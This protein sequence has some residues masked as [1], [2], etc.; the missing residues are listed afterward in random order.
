MRPTIEFALDAAQR[1]HPN[2]SFV[3]LLLN[4]A[5]IN[6]QADFDL[7][8]LKLFSWEHWAVRLRVYAGIDCEK[9]LGHGWIRIEIERPGGIPGNYQVVCR[10]CSGSGISRTYLQEE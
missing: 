3:E 6:D 5:R 7:E 9:C 2:D 1:A 4:A 10:E 8:T